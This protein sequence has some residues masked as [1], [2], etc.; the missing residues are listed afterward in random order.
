MKNKKN[1]KIAVVG[2]TGN[3]GR[4]FLQ[5]L[6]ERGYPVENISAVASS[7][8]AKRPIS[9]GENDIIT[10]QSLDKFDF[11]G[12]DYALFSP[13]GKISA[14]YAPKAATQGCVVIDNTSHFRMDEDIPL[15]VPEINSDALTDFSNRNIVANPNCSTIQMVMALKPLHD[16]AKIK[17][18]VVSTYQSVSGAGQEAMDELTQ[19]TKGLF[20]GLSVPP[21]NF[22]KPIAFN[23]IPQIDVFMEGDSTKEEWKMVVETQK[24][25]DPAIQVTATCVRVPVYIGHSLSLNIEFEQELSADKARQLLRQFKGITVMDNP[26]D[27][28]YATPLDGAGEDDVLISRIRKDPTVP[29]GL[30]MWVVADNVRKGAAL[31]AVQ[32]ME[33]LLPIR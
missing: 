22:S 28:S 30:N 9:Y 29:Y 15:V 20:T 19:Q 14:E 2:A 18:V 12:C 7:R 32:I 24:I 4:A 25:L 8:S 16:V 26:D 1:I 10:V 13:G 27:L 17:R 11:S 3:V 5:I 6:A 21:A 23:V 31:N 33:A